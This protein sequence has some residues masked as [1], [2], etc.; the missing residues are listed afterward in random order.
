MCLLMDLTLKWHLQK[1]E[2]SGEADGD[3]IDARFAC[4]LL[5]STFQKEIR[6]EKERKKMERREK[7]ERKK[8]MER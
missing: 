5:D 3:A 1:E 2:S 4:F 7:K 8:K 6:S